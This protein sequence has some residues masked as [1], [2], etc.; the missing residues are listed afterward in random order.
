MYSIEHQNLL[1]QIARDAIFEIFEKDG[2]D[3]VAPSG[4][5]ALRRNRFQ[6]LEKAAEKVPRFGKKQ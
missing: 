2:A 3:G 1:L 6:G 5:V 4:R